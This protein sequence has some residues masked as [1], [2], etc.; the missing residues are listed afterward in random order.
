MNSNK[1]FSFNRFYLLLRNDVLLNYKKYLFIIAAAFILGFIV[2]YTSMPQYFVKGGLIE[3]YGPSQYY[4]TFGICIIGLL[5]LVGSAFAGFS[6]KT[7]TLNYLQ[8]PASTFEK[9]LCQFVIFVLAGTILF[10]VIFWIDAHLA[11]FVVLINLKYSNG[12]IMGAEKYEYIEQF[13]Y[14][15]MVLKRLEHISLYNGIKYWNELI[16]PFIATFSIGMYLFNVKVVF[17]KAGLIKS[18]LTLVIFFSLAFILLTLLSQMFFPETKSFNISHRLSYT[19]INGLANID[20]WLSSLVC[21]SPFFIIPFG[22]FKLKEK[23]L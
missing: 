23:Q 1:F 10:F 20:I 19:L 3:G 12:E 15:T 13:S 18:A 22:Y 14:N 7:S 5:A 4:K 21:I 9:Y 16:M 8:M 11:R 2:L 17:K 6:S